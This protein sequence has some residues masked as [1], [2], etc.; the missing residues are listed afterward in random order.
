MNDQTHPVD[1]NE[2]LKSE[3]ELL[4]KRIIQLESLIVSSEIINSKFELHSVLNILMT[5]VS[6]VVDSEAASILLMD[7][8]KGQLYFFAA[9]G[10][11]KDALNKIYIGRGEGIAGWVAANEK[12][13][14]V[15]DVSKDPRF[16]GKTD[17]ESGFITKSILAVPLKIEDRLIGVAEAVNKKNGAEFSE[18]DVHLI[19]SLATNGALAIQKAQLYKDLNDLFLGTIRA[20]TSAIDA[21]DPYTHGHSERVC[22]YSMMIAKELGVV[23]DELKIVELS[24]LLHDIGKIG[25]PE[26]ILRKPGKLTDEEWAE[27][28]RHPTIGADM[29]TSIKQLEK[30]IPGIRHH[31]ERFDGQGYPTGLW[32]ENIPISAR[33]IAVADTFDAM[34][35]DRPYRN[36][37][38]KTM[39][40]KE[41]QIYKNI[42]FDSKCV[43][44]FIAGLKK[45]HGGEIPE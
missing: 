22:D 2:K 31:Q 43:D 11:K 36:K 32:G 35:S 26:A 19:S 33:I 45:K 14:I 6:Q 44:A 41:L 7:E 13:V 12:P 10:E 24:S 5:I 15:S 21:K 9:S 34:T 30:I 39:A 28:R 1:E 18:E 23:E 17:K 29:L 25:V 27:L 4:K 8:V 20:L 37:F 42:Q 16:T 38:P 40:V 3:I